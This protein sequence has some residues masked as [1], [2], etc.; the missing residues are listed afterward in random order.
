MND[1]KKIPLFKG[2]VKYYNWSESEVIFFD[3]TSQSL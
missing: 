3:K 2:L 1:K